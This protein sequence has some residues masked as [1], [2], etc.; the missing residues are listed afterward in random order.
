MAR[1][2]SRSGSPAPTAS[3]SRVSSSRP[4]ARNAEGSGVRALSH[5]LT[6]NVET[7]W[8]SLRLLRFEISA[9]PRFVVHHLLRPAR[10]ARS[11]AG[12]V[13]P[14]GVDADEARAALAL[15]VLARLEPLRE[16]L[17]RLARSPH[18]P[19]PRE[20]PLE[21]PQLLAL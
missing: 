16:L 21:L 4:P 13:A 1:G 15:G 10:P 20:P 11:D 12:A 2:L 9:S 17:E 5:V 14:L 6:G 3:R 8:V 7:G 18:E 19:R